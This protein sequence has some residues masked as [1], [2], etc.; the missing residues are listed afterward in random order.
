M[1]SPCRGCHRPGFTYLSH[2]FACRRESQATFAAGTL[3]LERRI[4]RLEAASRC[5]LTVRRIIAA[6]LDA[7]DQEIVNLS[8]IGVH[9]HR[10]AASA[11]V[12]HRVGAGDQDWRH[13][14]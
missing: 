12:V 9:Q 2:I 13:T 4:E 6:A 1:A 5:G 8:V 14:Y 10:P 11:A 7:V 3:F